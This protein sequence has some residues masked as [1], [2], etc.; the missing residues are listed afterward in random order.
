MKIVH[1]R[2]TLKI[3][4]TNSKLLASGRNEQ[5]MQFVKMATLR[6]KT[7]Y[8]KEEE[9]GPQLLQSEVEDSTANNDDLA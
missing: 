9:M 8:A 2:S 1:E 3:T 7:E 4:E 6:E 5:P